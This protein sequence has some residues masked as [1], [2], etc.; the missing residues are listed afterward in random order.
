MTAEERF[1]DELTLYARVLGAESCW[2]RPITMS[3]GGYSRVTGGT[4]GMMY[5]HR[6]AYTKLVGPIPEGL[7]IDHLC[8]VKCCVNP[9]HMEC[10]TL[11]EN[12]RRGNHYRGDRCAKGHPLTP[13]NLVQAFL[14]RNVRRC[15]TCYNA[16][17]RLDRAKKKALLKGSGNFH[18]LD[19]CN[20][21]PP[22]PTAP[23]QSETRSLG[24]NFSG[25]TQDPLS[26]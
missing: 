26:S 19:Q 5:A 4:Y 16:W 8:R 23:D 13:D 11:A 7:T 24:L 3:P 10:V 20:N 9:Q 6:L 2:P 1:Y 12:S 22:P 14:K 15:R 17:Q 18:N 21:Q 25:H